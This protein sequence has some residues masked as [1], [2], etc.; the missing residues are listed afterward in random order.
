MLDRLGDQMVLS[1]VI[2][3]DLGIPMQEISG[4]AA[5]EISEGVAQLYYKST[6]TFLPSRVLVETPARVSA[7][8][9]GDTLPRATDE[10]QLACNKNSGEVDT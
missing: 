5:A 1:N 9:A 7:S 4:A 8:D 6:S 2:L 3:E 10:Q